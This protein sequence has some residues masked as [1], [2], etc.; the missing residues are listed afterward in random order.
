MSQ[1]NMAKIAFPGLYKQLESLGMG[2]VV[3]SGCDGAVFCVGM[4]TDN[5]LMRISCLSCGITSNWLQPKP[6]KEIA[7]G[8]VI[9]TKANA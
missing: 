2:T 1:L 3:C 7:A 9:Q 8:E 4:D 6:T 5:G